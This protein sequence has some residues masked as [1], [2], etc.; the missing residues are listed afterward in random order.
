MPIAF[1]IQAHVKRSWWMA[2][3]KRLQVL[4]VGIVGG[5]GRAGVEEKL[6]HCQGQ[7][8][9]WPYIPTPCSIPHSLLGGEMGIQRKAWYAECKSCEWL[10]LLGY[11][12]LALPKS[13]SLP[14]TMSKEK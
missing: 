7:G 10:F 4:A 14:I 12:V 13:L 1:S 2:K 6:L 9:M 8:H 11:K 5:V 3:P